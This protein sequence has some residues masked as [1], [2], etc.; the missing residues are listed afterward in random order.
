MLQQ[1]ELG[2]E[3]PGNPTEAENFYT[4]SCYNNDPFV[5]KVVLHL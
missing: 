4:V 2:R 5:V 1:D 3:F